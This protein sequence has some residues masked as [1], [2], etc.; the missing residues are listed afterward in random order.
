MITGYRPGNSPLHR[1][2]AGVKLAALPVVAI[3]LFQLSS[4]VGTVAAVAVGM[5]CY[6]LGGM[7]PWLAWP[8]LRPFLLVL[9]AIFAVQWLVL[10]LLP[11]AVI[12]LRLLV[13]VAL[14]TLVT[15][16]TRTEDVVGAIERLPVRGAARLGLM[17]ALTLRAVSVLTET[18]R[19]IREA[20]RARGVERSLIAFVLPFVIRTLK[21]AD[22]LGEALA[23]R[24]IDD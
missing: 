13:A 6:L 9:V 11:A 12:C 1:T 15:L 18:A 19:E 2:P 23:A 5:V 3:A 22:T 20:Q 17:V 14:A 8:H 24:G 7:W 21:Y 4:L 10:G 16:T